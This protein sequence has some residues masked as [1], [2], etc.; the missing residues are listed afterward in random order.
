MSPGVI[1][2]HSFK[3]MYSLLLCPHPS[4][5]H[6][7]VCT[8]MV[9]S[10]KALL[11]TASKLLPG[12]LYISVVIT[13][14][15]FIAYHEWHPVALQVQVD[16]AAGDICPGAFRGSNHPKALGHRNDPQR[17]AS[18][19]RQDMCFLRT[20]PLRL[21]NMRLNPIIMPHILLERVC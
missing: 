4:Q 8:R 16:G 5:P 9:P 17:F 7:H 21:R 18:S 14:D 2:D 1:H 15:N 10:P 19:T 20:Q 6:T 3:I 12:L 11:P 13:P